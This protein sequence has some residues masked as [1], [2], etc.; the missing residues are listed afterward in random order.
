M[1]KMIAG[2]GKMKMKNTVE[3]ITVPVCIDVTHSDA[4]PTHG[5]V[6]MMMTVEM[7]K[8]NVTALMRHA[9]QISSLATTGVAYL[10]NTGVMVMMTVEMVQMRNTVHHAATLLT[11]NVTLGNALT[12]CLCVMV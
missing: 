8:M 5:C 9:D 10:T 1:A 12:E 4:F 6:T 7:E 3:A 11:S 2:R